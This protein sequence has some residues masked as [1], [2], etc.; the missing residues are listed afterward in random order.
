MHFQPYVSYEKY[1]LSIYYFSS[2]WSNLK[3]QESIKT[4]L[5]K[6]GCVCVRIEYQMMYFENWKVTNWPVKWAA[7]STS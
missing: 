3:F 2:Y 4:K 7:R 1:T 5:F 6:K